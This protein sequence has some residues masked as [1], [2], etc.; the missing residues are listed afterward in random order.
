MVENVSVKLKKIS[1]IYKSR[2]ILKYN[3]NQKLKLLKISRKY[4]IVEGNGEN[5]SLKKSI[6]IWRKKL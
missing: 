3:T 5:N 1:Y 2:I 4:G 6:F